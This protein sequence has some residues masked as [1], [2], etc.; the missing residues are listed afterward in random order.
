M[1]PKLILLDLSLPGISGI[2]GLDK[3]KSMN[4]EIQIIVLTAS[5][6]KKDVFNAISKGAAGYLLKNTPIDHIIHA[7]EDVISGGASLD[8]HIASMVLEAFSTAGKKGS[9]K[10]DD[11][12]YSL[13]NR[14]IEVL[15]LLAEGKTIKEISE[16]I[17]LSSH[18]IKFHVANTYKKLNVQSQAGAVAKG[19]RHGII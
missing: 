9:S 2:E 7:V 8:P 13:T 18:T 10:K 11:S 5:D 3:I 6:Q 19:I 17:N 12:V 16:L 4:P 14:E 15:E 1:V